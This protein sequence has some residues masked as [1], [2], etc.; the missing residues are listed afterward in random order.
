MKKFVINFLTLTVFMTVLC[1]PGLPVW[2]A[3]A[4]DKA[5]AYPE[6]V[7]NVIVPYSLGGTFATLTRILCDAASKDLNQR[8]TITP[9]PGAGTVLGIQKALS[10]DPDGYTLLMTATSSFSIRSLVRSLRFKLED[11]N[12]ICGIGATV[13]YLA[14]SKKGR[15]STLEDMIAFAKQNPGKVTVAFLGYGGFH[16]VLVSSFER[17]TGIKLHRVPYDSGQQAISAVLGGHVDTMVEDVYNADLL[18]LAIAARDRFWAYPNTPTFLE[19]GY[20]DLPIDLL[21]G[22]F[23]APGTPES[24]MQKLEKAFLKATKDQAY[25]ELMKNLRYMP[26]SLDRAG[27]KA[28][29]AAEAATTKAL[30]DSGAIQ[31]QQ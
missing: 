8:I 5:D 17:S 23:A 25:T 12:P 18:P 19:K 3:R 11:A 7:I 2:E 29:I 14:A 31:R 27:T 6:R 20:K 30:L 4:A 15:F 16:D 24:I 1:L 26:L 10:A 21:I 22:M 13:T 9:M 28:S